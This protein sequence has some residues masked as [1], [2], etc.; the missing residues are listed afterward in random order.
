MMYVYDSQWRCPGDNWIGE[1]EA[2]EGDLGEKH[3]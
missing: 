2:P 1:S 3:G